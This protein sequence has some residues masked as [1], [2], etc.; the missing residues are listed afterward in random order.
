MRGKR[1]DIQGLRAIA[2]LLVIANH[3]VGWPNGGFIGVD[4][5]FVISGFL[6]TGFLLREH[7][8]VGRV[9]LRGFYMRRIK[10]ILPAA[11]TVTAATV[12]LANLLFSTARAGSTLVDGLFSSVFVANWRFVAIGT[13]YMHADDS[14]SPL[15]HYWSL[16]VEEQFYLIWPI[17]IILTLAV[18]RRYPRRYVTAILAF[19]TIASF[20]WALWESAA[21][22]TWAYF[23]TASRAWELGIGAL[24]ACCT[25]SLSRLPA[26]IRPLLVLGGLAAI[27]ISTFEIT[28][29]SVFPAPWA[30][31]PVLGTAAIIAA[32]IGQTTRA[33]YPIA[34]PATSYLGEISFSLYLWHFPVIVFVGELLPQRGEKYLLASLMLTVLLSIATYHWIE[35]PLR[36]ATWSTSGFANALKATRGKYSV[37]PALLVCALAVGVMTFQSRL[38]E[39]SAEAHEDSIAVLL[40]SSSPTAAESARS[41]Q[42]RDALTLSEWPELSPP[43]ESLGVHDRAPEWVEDGCAIDSTVENSSTPAQTVR[44][45]TFGPV[46]AKHTIAVLGDSTAI[47]YVPAIRAAAGNDT[48]IR[49]YIMEQCPATD[50][51]VR[52]WSG[53]SASRCNPFRVW[54]LGEI[55]ST[56]PDVVILASAPTTIRRLGDRA[57]STDALVEWEAGTRRLFDQLSMA[58]VISLDPPPTMRSLQDCAVPGSTPKDCVFAPEQDFIDVGR[59]TRE[60]A[61]E[62]TNVTVPSTIEWFCSANGEC[63][64][65]V[66][67]TPILVDGSHL[68]A[69]ASVELAP[70]LREM[71]A[72]RLTEASE[73]RG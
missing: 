68:T 20:G 8:R 2:V 35:S 19:L 38:P 15:Q 16:S 28:D 63:P 6:I 54:A 67:S 49:L 24:L 58:T 26:R 5:F 4:L 17:V 72:G 47:S 31:V 60:V 11:L 53:E 71:L 27:G 33:S 34:N 52:L 55:R 32:G 59:V 56:A 66:G 46:N 29:A 7:E 42:I 25:T 45:C 1:Q 36:R 18:A 30:L 14:V 62:Y 65:F 73:I 44:R 70:F 57:T 41:A 23:S 43:I 51:S 9:S 61:S 3:L 64:L 21:Q 40:G 22:P 12:V 13:D 50:V 39:A 48:M 37:L 10:R 69:A